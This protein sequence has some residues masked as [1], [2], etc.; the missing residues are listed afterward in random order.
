MMQGR[1]LIV[2]LIT[3]VIGFGVGFVTRPVIL[4]PSP[5]AIVAAPSLAPSPPASARG[6]PYFA[7]HLD[8]A[9]RI[10]AGC[11]AGTVLDDEC[12]NAEQAV[13]EADGRAR[14]K[15]FLGK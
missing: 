11:A 15:H 10:V 3:L 13:T 8:V 9:R 14:L 12:A 2:V 5:A 4:P 7:A 6:K 1:M